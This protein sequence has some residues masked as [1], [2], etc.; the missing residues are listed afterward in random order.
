MA[1]GVVHYSQVNALV[2]AMLSRL[3]GPDEWPRLLAATDLPDVVQILAETSYGEPLRGIA[4]LDTATLEKRLRLT[5]VDDYDRL[6]RLL[7]G[8]PRAIVEEL[9]RRRELDNL[10]AI[11]RAVVGRMPR[12]P[13]RLLLFPIGRYSRLPVDDLLR[14]ENLS[15]AA[16]V[17]DR[18]QYGRAL[19]V[20]LERYTAEDSLFPV[21]VALDLAYYRRLWS[22][23]EALKGLDYATARRL[24]GI[25]YDTLNLDWLL[26]FR[27]LYRLSPEEIFNYTLPFGYRL[28]DRIIR[29]AA[30]ASDLPGIAAELPE[31]YRGQLRGLGIEPTAVEQAEVRLNRYLGEVA[32]STFAGY[33]FQIGEV[34][35]YLW[36]KEA[37]VH[38]LEVILEG[39]STGQPPELMSALLW[40]PQQPVGV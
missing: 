38:D 3:L 9:L 8:T 35:A 29:R 6:I 37:E 21:E 5:I 32:R 4:Q 23:V 36:L 13:V 40:S 2:R 16:E 11:L 24:V 31:P 17:L 33:P 7:K 27:L 10:K 15:E 1:L 14:A 30:E 18:T 22:E 34:L 28:T 20:S 25:R 19:R 39:K 12:E 26:R